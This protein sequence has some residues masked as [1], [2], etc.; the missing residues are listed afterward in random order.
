MAGAALGAAQ[1][2]QSLL[3]SY[4]TSALAAANTALENLSNSDY[5]YVTGVA[6]AFSPFNPALPVLPAAPTTLAI[7]T[8]PMVQTITAPA[9]PAV[10]SITPPVAPDIPGIV[11]P[12][13]PS[14]SSVTMDNIAAPTFEPLPAMP[15]WAEVVIENLQV[16]Y[17]QDITLSPYV[18]SFTNEDILIKD[19]PMVAAIMD[20]I[21][22][23]L[24]GGSG[25]TQDVEDAIFNRDLERNEQTLEDTTD[26]MVAMWAK[27]GFSLPDGLL[28]HSLSEVQKEYMNKK[29]DRSREIAIKQADLEQNNL[30]KSM[31]AGVSLAFKLIEQLNTYKEM[32]FKIE[33][34][35]V[36]YANEYLDMQIKAHNAII[37]VLKAKIQLHELNIRAQT[38]KVENYKAQ[39]EALM[40]IN[41]VNENDVRLYSSQITAAVEKYRGELSGDTV[42]AQIFSTQMQGVLAQSQVN[43]SIIKSYAEQV[44]AGLA[45]AEVYKAEVEGMAAEVGAQKLIIEANIAQVTA[46]AKGADAQIAAHNSDVEIFKATGQMALAATELANKTAEV[47]FRGAIEQSKILTANAQI[48]AGSIEAAGKSRIAAAS[49]V[50]QAASSLAAGAMAAVHAQASF[51][52][53][54]T[55]QLSEQ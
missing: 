29:I 15:I 12:V 48:I 45:Q 49:G 32:V 30:F 4:A 3:T 22:N 55:M 21:T 33:E 9:P 40:A 27:K 13:P 7:G 5:A 36:K 44:R 50:A 2:Q 23:N 17:P 34:T 14:M 37:D 47:A 54:E 52:Y 53:A 39:I 35:V 51:S 38:V 11:I 19:D 42:K 31:E 1:S 43:E 16:E 26:K 6:N 46:W 8:A 10:P 20:R 41:G 18:P 28:A 25:L 24:S